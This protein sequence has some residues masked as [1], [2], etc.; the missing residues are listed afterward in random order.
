M[1]FHWGCAWW[2]QLRSYR[3]SRADDVANLFQRFGASSDGYL[4]TDN[5]LDYQ[6]S[7]VSSTPSV[8][9]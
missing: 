4:E 2:P 6:E 5:S 8:A 9:L 3:M 1:L 7:S